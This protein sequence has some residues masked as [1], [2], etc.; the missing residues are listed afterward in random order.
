MKLIFTLFLLLNTINIQAKQE[1]FTTVKLNHMNAKEAALILKPLTDKAISIN[2]NNNSIIIKGRKSKIK[3]II[4]LIKKID[5]PA[6]PLTL[7]FIVSKQKINFKQSKNTYELNRNSSSQSMSIIARQW[8]NLNTGISIPITERT[9]SAN[10]AVSESIRYKKIAKNYLFKVYEF[11][12]QSIIQVVVNSSS[13]NSNTAGAIEQ[14]KINT[15]IIGKTGEWLEVSS[16]REIK[17][18]GNDHVYGTNNSN[19]KHI[20][21]YIKITK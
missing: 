6:L 12:G 9:Y 5:T 2:T 4:Q 1:H 13:L 10:G 20:H 16:S 11:N 17:K 14:I 7:E 18:F 15:T 21:L 3:S 19:K 8:V